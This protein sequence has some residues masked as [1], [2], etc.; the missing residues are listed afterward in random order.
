[1]SVGRAMYAVRAGESFDNN[2][3]AES[4]ADECATFTRFGNPFFLCKG[5]TVTK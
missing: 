5:E 4:M 2:Y 1:M 3:R